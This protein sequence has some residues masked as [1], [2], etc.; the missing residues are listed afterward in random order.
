MVN[1]VES[2]DP[3]PEDPKPPKKAKRKGRR[4]IA[5]V[6]VVLVIAI[7][8]VGILLNGNSN[9]APK[10]EFEIVSHEAY[11]ETNTTTNFNATVA[12]RVN[13]TG[14]V[15]GN[16]TVI[17]KVKNAGYTW[18]GAQ[19]FYMEPG[20]SFYSYKLHIPVNGDA[21]DNWKYQCFINGEKAVDYPHN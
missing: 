13:N 8:V 14:T 18:A 16:V 17:F 19:I 10:P 7:V 11:A 6:A 15:P 9:P 12:F 4:T 5:I 20:Q 3:K 2:S 1:S 21:D